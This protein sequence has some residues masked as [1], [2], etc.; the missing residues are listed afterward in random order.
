MG[1]PGS[2]S[3]RYPWT[4]IPVERRKEYMASLEA[5]SSK[6]IIAPFAEFLAGLVE[7]GLK[8]EATAE[9]PAARE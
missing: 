4:V 7:R 5:A 2:Q 9:L 8:G 1:C 6:Q 3:D